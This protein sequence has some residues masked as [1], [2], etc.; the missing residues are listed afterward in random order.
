MVRP[1]GL[2]NQLVDRGKQ[3]ALAPCPLDEGSRPGLQHRRE[4]AVADRRGGRAVDRF[5]FYLL[6]PGGVG[7]LPLTDSKRTCGPL[8]LL[9]SPRVFED[10]KSYPKDPSWVS[11]LVARKNVPPVPTG[12]L[13]FCRPS[14]DGGIDL[15]RDIRVSVSPEPG[16]HIFT[17]FHP[18]ALSVT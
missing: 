13:A 3:L 10:R 18:T 6:R 16:P 17:P 15:G 7:D 14:S 1:V 2:R 8:A 4:L 9:T 12:L 5:G 11:V